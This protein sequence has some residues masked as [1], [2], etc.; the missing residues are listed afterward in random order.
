MVRVD[1]SGAVVNRVL[2][3]AGRCLMVYD[4]CGYVARGCAG[5][6]VGCVLLGKDM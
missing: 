6:L 3:E 5:R 1:A 4:V 2:S